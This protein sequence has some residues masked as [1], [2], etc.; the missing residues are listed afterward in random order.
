MLYITPVMKHVS[1]IW[2]HSKCTCT[3]VGVLSSHVVMKKPHITTH[4]TSTVAA[5]AWWNKPRNH[6]FYQSSVNFSII[7]CSCSSFKY[8]FVLS[9]T[10]QILCNL[11]NTFLVVCPLLIIDMAERH[12]SVVRN[13]ILLEH[14]P[15]NL[16][17]TYI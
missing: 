1:F 12:F 2:I 6:T 3:V 15:I 7:S 10:I 4:F 17:D 13:V 16:S 8:N 11:I 14:V 5:V 9:V